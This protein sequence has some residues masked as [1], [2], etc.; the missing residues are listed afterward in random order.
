MLVAEGAVENPCVL[1]PA[2][3][4][5]HMRLNMLVHMFVLVSVERTWLCGGVAEWDRGVCDP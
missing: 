3:A 2:C 1:V 5:K 4:R